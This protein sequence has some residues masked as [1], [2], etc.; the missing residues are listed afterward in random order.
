[1]RTEPVGVSN[2]VRAVLIEVDSKAFH[3]PFVLYESLQVTLRYPW[4]NSTANA[5]LGRPS[6]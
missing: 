4:G 1:M 6:R 2:V 3:R 5:K